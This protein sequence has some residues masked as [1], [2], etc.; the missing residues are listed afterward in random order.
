[1]AKKRVIVDLNLRGTNSVAELE[2]E[3]KLVNQELKLVDRN[4]DAFTE[5]SQ[6]Q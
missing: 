3:L 4:S 2:Q 5:L 6:K 1:M